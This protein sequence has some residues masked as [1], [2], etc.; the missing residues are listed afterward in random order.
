MQETSYLEKK[1]FALCKTL[2]RVNL[3]SSGVKMIEAKYFVGCIKLKQVVLEGARFLFFNDTFRDY[4]S[5]EYAG[6]DN[7]QWKLIMDNYKFGIN[8][9]YIT[10]FDYGTFD[11]YSSFEC[12]KWNRENILLHILSKC[13][14]KD[15]SY[16]ID[17]EVL[18]EIIKIWLTCI[19]N[20]IFIL[21]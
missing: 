10:D 7:L 9:P 21:I 19:K 18:Y 3:L 5:I 2:Q 11:E 16:S 20:S 14:T 8:L 12:I 1:N 15:I 6:Y 17:S 13:I 4:N